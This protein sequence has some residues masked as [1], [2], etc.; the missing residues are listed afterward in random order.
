MNQNFARIVGVVVI[1]G[2]ALVLPTQSAS[3]QSAPGGSGFAGVGTTI[4]GL[5]GGTGSGTGL[6]LNPLLISP[7][8][9]STGV[10]IQ[11]VPVP[12]P[13]AVPV[14]IERPIIESARA[15]VEVVPAKDACTSPD[16][17][18]IF[19]TYAENYCRGGMTGVMNAA[20]RA[21]EHM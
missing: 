6:P 17:A 19:P 14:V 1:A 3:A 11:E 10:V 13:V 21:S 15:P 18:R 4:P 5:S 2:F 16:V 8:L 7:F 20:R 9:Q 12:V